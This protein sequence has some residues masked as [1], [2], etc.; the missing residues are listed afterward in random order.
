MSLDE[1]TAIALTTL[2]QEATEEVN[3]PEGSGSAQS[4]DREAL[5]GHALPV[6]IDCVP[7]HARVTEASCVRMHVAARGKSDPT[8]C[9]RCE[10]GAQ[11]AGLE[12]PTSLATWRHRDLMPGTVVDGYEVLASP[13]PFK[14]HGPTY[15][16]VRRLSDGYQ[17][18]VDI[19]KLR[20]WRRAAAGVSES[21]IR[22][23][24]ARGMDEAQAVLTPPCP[25][26]GIER[27]RWISEVK[28]H[29]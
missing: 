19:A 2:A 22:K 8:A 4:D 7:R 9:R 1:G 24:K 11:R 3:P 26:K 27:L 6:L 29:G 15:V 10:V 18:S 23:R 12:S 14:W 13:P 21:A 20:K 17:T 25:P 5:I 16:Y 28:A